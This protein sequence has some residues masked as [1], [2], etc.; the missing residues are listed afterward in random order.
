MTMGIVTLAEFQN[1][2][3]F[4]DEDERQQ[5]YIDSA[6]NILEKYLGY[7]PEEREYSHLFDGNGSQILQL[8]ARPLS[9]IT[10][11]INNVEIPVDEF[12]A[13]NEFI[14]YKNGIFPEGKYNIEIEYRGGYPA[15]E[16][17]E[18]LRITVLRLG[19]LLNT[20][21]QGNIGVTS[22]S[23]GDSGS[24]TFL[25]NTDYNRYL[26]PVSAYCLLRI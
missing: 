14:Y 19:A 11:K 24:R 10:V 2:T 20:E 12:T 16:I 8:R 3:S 6:E 21:A 4:F 9:L 18:L 23:F 7:H 5:I 17:P 22:K 13:A 26:L 1:Y 25:N 15:G